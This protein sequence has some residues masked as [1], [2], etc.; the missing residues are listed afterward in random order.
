MHLVEYERAEDPVCFLASFTKE[1][2]IKIIRLLLRL[3]AMIAAAQLLVHFGECHQRHLSLS[4]SHS[5][6]VTLANAKAATSA[7]QQRTEHQIY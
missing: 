5:A 3:T 7:A 4:L 6:V 1:P 2:S